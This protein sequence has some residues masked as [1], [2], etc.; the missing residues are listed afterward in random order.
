MAPASRATNPKKRNRY[1]DQG[2]LL[3]GI[4]EVRK[5]RAKLRAAQR[6]GAS[7]EALAGL[8]LAL[9]KQ[10]AQAKK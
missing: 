8:R 3:P 6:E 4:R 7:E 9:K 10:K 5:I 2:E 1:N